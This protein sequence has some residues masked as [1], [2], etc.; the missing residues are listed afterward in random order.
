[1]PEKDLVGDWWSF[2]QSYHLYNIAFQAWA[3]SG[4]LLGRP[5]QEGEL[6]ESPLI[7]KFMANHI[8]EVSVFVCND[9]C[10]PSPLCI[11]LHIGIPC[12]MLPNSCLLSLKLF[13]KSLFPSPDSNKAFLSHPPRHI[14]SPQ[15][16]K[17][18]RPPHVQRPCW[19]RDQH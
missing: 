15:A 5:L 17:H 19:P 3:P 18:S 12:R 10:P 16:D 9:S 14:P 11:V 8:A 13:F 6:Q 2:T 1:M 4:I 7:R